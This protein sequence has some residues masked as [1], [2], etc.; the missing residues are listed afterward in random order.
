MSYNCIKYYF[1]S[2]PNP[3]AVKSLTNF[4]LFF[5]NF[6]FCLPPPEIG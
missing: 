5:E 6:L 4:L 1:V 3:L 2:I